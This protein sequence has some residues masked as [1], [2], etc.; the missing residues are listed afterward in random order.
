MLAIVNFY[1]AHFTTMGR[2]IH[3]EAYQKGVYVCMYIYVYVYVYIYVCVYVYVY[4][5]VVRK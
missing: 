4:L 3:N 1:Q 5:Y 2:S